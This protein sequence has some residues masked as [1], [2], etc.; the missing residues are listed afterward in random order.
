MSEITEVELY[1][2]QFEILSDYSWKRAFELDITLTPISYF[3]RDLISGILLSVYPDIVNYVNKDKCKVSFSMS[4][5]QTL[6][7]YAA[8]WAEKLDNGVIEPDVYLYARERI[9][10]IKK[11]VEQQFEVNN[12]INE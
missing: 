1:C 9:A 7:S 6:L 11:I 8:N 10:E 5:W 4:H 3:N 2:G 12:P